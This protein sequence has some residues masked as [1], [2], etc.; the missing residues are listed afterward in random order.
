MPLGWGRRSNLLNLDLQH[1]WSVLFVRKCEDFTLVLVHFKKQ[2]VVDCLVVHAFFHFVSVPLVSLC[3]SRVF[4]SS[5]KCCSWLSFPSS[6]CACFKLAGAP[7]W[8][9]LPG[10]SALHLGL[11]EMEGCPRTTTSFYSSAFY[12]SA[13]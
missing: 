13:E 2:N 3:G 6:C 4:V 12:S 10:S 11:Q 1:V 7:C 5:L 9:L 8:F